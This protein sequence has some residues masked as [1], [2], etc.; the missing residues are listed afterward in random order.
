MN[1][2]C[3]K[4]GH[5]AGS[6][7]GRTPL[8]AFRADGCY[9]CAM[10]RVLALCLAA[11]AVAGCKSRQLSPYVSPRLTGRVLA[12]DTRQ[13][14]AGVQ[15]NRA[16]S[17]GQRGNTQLDKGGAGLM[18]GRVVRTDNGGYFMLEAERVLAPL[19]GAGWFSADLTFQC[20]GYERFRTNYSYLNLSTNTCQGQPALS[21][22]DILLQPA[23][24]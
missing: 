5:E 6:Q 22:G 15:V 3:P 24:K 16:E 10:N 14:L 4:S 7:S 13:P 8:F 2:H 18:A 9:H 21:A 17:A 12:A 20:P 23:R 11:L 1:Q 19:W